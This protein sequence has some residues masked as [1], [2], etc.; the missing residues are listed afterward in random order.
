MMLFTA[1]QSPFDDG[2]ALGR[3]VPD[4]GVVGH[5]GTLHPERDVHV[6]G[7]AVA[8]GLVVDEHVLGD[9][10]PRVVDHLDR[11]AAP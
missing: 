9:E 7:A 11:P 8:V 2:R 6:E 1:N 10:R 5:D 4:H 3:P